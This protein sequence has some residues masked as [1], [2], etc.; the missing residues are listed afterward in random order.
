[1]HKNFSSF[2]ENGKAMLCLHSLKT[3]SFYASHAGNSTGFTIGTL[4]R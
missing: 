3:D 2:K 4:N 1:M